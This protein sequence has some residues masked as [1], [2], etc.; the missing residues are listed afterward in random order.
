MTVIEA[1]PSRSF[2]SHPSALG[3]VRQH[4]RDRA[5]E[6]GFS[7]SQI[8]EL[9][10]AVS[11]ACTNAILHSG[12]D[13]VTVRWTVSGDCAEIRISDAGRFRVRVRMPE[14]EGV[15]GHGIPLMTA[16]SDRIEITKG[17][18]RRPGTTV[19]LVKCRHSE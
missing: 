10:L 17:T 14:I 15:G 18:S 5:S 2:P 11:E 7:Q 13:R 12:T 19:L 3:E 4:I 16:L 8:E 9:V 6:D 1:G